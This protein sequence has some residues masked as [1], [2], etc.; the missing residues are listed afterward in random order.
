MN[1]RLFIISYLSLSL[2]RPLS[3]P[4]LLLN[5]PNKGNYRGSRIYVTI[6]FIC[7]KT[8]IEGLRS[9]TVST[10]ACTIDSILQVSSIR[11]R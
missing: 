6:Y 2:G 1:L 5:F 10:S 3:N 8:Y 4:M 9:A 7:H 11:R